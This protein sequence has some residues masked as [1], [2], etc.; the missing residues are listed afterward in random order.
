MQQLA[1]PTQAMP[2]PPLQAWVPEPAVMGSA[3]R[4]AGSRPLG[5]APQAPSTAAAHAPLAQLAP[6]AAPVLIDVTPRALVVETVGGFCDTIIP[7]NAKIPCER[8]RAFATSSDQQTIVRV[9]VAQGEDEHFGAN[10]YLG[11]LE[12]AGLRP[13]HR[14]EVTIAVRF[15]VDANGTLQVSATDV[16]TK[17]EARA[18]LQLVGVAGEQQVARMQQR[19]AQMRVGS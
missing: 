9:R 14:G 19:H 2:A 15:E 11:E 4:L 5:D 12:L 6:T 18:T 10:V 7:R 13:A 8:T 17:R 3:T 1:P 16:A